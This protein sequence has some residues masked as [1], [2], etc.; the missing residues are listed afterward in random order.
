MLSPFLSP[1][2]FPLSSVGIYLSLGPWW[3]YY[4]DSQCTVKKKFKKERNS[5]KL[6]KA[7]DL[8]TKALLVVGCVGTS[9]SLKTLSPERK[10]HRKTKPKQKPRSV[11]CRTAGRWG[12][13]DFFLLYLLPPPSEHHV[14]EDGPFPLLITPFGISVSWSR[15]HLIIC[16]CN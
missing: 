15:I 8:W 16:T 1:P 2:S 6:Y 12:A 5:Y 11:A 14:A 3:D 13:A 9:R 7:E 10:L 4:R